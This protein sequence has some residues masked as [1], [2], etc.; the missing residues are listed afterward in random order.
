[1]HCSIYPLHYSQWCLKRTIYDVF[2]INRELRS[3]K[4]MSKEEY[5]LTVY[6]S[7]MELIENLTWKELTG[8]TE[9]EFTD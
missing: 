3:E 8:I 1:M 4:Y 2:S 6:S 9:K 5:Y 7:A